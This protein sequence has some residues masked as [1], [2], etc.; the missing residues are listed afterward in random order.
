MEKNF[1]NM[2]PHYARRAQLLGGGITACRQTL[3]PAG[4]TVQTGLRDYAPGDAVSRVDWGICARHDE[5]RVREFRGTA[6]RHVYLM[7]DVSCSMKVDAA[8]F[9]LARQSAMTV[10][11][12]LLCENAYVTVFTWAQRL[13]NMLHPVMGRLRTGRVMRFL[14][15]TCVTEKTT[16]FSAAV[17]EFCGL[18]MPRGQV[19]VLSDFFA[20]TDDFRKAYAPG[21][22]RFQADGYEV[23]AIHVTSQADRGEGIRGDVEIVDV[24]SGYRQAITLTEREVRA[25]QALYDAYVHSVGDFCRSRRIPYTEVATGMTRDTACLAALGIP[26]KK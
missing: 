25:Y 26:T 1:Q 15:D 7:L 12:T 6:V 20:D 2:L 17:E 13:E 4:G 18:G 3:L 22:S 14:D 5:L 8:K 10:A 23:R 11:Y 16:D 19:F 21:F 24:E 9:A